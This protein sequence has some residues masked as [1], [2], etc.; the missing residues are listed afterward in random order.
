MSKVIHVAVGVVAVN[1]KILIARRPPDVHQGDLWEFP[2]GK[3][4]QGEQVLDALRRELREELGIDI[5]PGH[6]FP[7]KRILHRYGDRAVLLDTWRVDCFQGEP[8]GREN[9]DVIWRSVEALFPQDFPEANR[10]IIK[11]LQLPSELAITGRC[12]SRT[13]FREKMAGLVAQDIKLI[14]FRQPQLTGSEFL[15]WAGDA[16]RL[17]REND[18]RLLI[19]GSLEAFDQLEAH[20]FHATSARLNE[21]ESR[22]V[23]ESRLFSASCHNV[24][25]LLKAE[26]LG[27]DFALLSPVKATGTHVDA[28]P[29]GWE[30][31]RSHASQVSL[32]VYALGGMTLDDLAAARNEG[33]HGIAAISA[34]W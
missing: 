24:A 34:F 33:A 29:L 22:P 9:Q 6:C 8:V 13:E 15:D 2:G 4:E 19:N 32:P 28:Q 1:Q 16:L 17:C 27:A 11:A 23:S 5:D 30:R 26:E 25:E 10:A 12:E 20:G 31:F 18:A 3:L 7:L 21:L 14:Q